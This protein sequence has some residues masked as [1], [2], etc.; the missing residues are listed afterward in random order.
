MHT[1][2]SQSTIDAVQVELSKVYSYD[3][4]NPN[5]VVSCTRK[6][7]PYIKISP[8]DR[9]AIGQYAAQNGIAAAMH[10]FHQN[11]N[12]PDLKETSVRG[13]KDG[14]LKELQVQERKCE[15]ISISELP[16][17][18]RGRPLMLGKQLEKEV[19]SFIKAIQDSGGVVNTQIVIATTRGVI[20]SH[21]V[22]L[23]AEN[24]GYMNITKDWAK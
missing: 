20:M 15:P 9:A 23:L 1:D 6:R 5:S 8:K 21:D 10:H 17:K 22:N 24:G 16:E 11:G 19:Q 18:R 13:W 12:F 7:G 2:I 14:Y 4:T 3:K